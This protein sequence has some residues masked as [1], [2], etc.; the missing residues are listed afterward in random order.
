MDFLSPIEDAIIARLKEQMPAILVQPYPDNPEIWEPTH[1]VGA[2]LVRYSDGEYSPPLDTAVVVQER[3]LMW[4]V[5]LALWSLRG[6]AGQNGLYAYLEAVRTALTGFRPSHCQRAMRPVSEEFI[7][8]AAG[9]L[10]NKTQR[11]WQYAITF[12]TAT[13]NIEVAEEEQAPLL[14]RITAMDEQ[15]NQTTEV[16]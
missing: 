12:S 2:L 16:P 9:N 7:A 10:K 5:T 1:P 6:K 4:E 3:E 11:L 8:R 14:T 13:L 15:L